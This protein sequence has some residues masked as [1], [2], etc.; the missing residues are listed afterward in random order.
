M[1]KKSF[2]DC[3]L[4]ILTDYNF[5]VAPSSFSLLRPNQNKYKFFKNYFY[6]KYT[7]PVKKYHTQNF[8]TF[9]QL[10]RKWRPI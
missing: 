8:I 2:N 1:K 6:W 9:S 4:M 3:F 10:F 5:G 7:D